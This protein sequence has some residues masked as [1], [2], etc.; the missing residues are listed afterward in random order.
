MKVPSIFLPEKN[1]DKKVADLSSAKPYKIKDLED[2]VLWSGFDT[3]T[4][5]ID[6]SDDVLDSYSLLNWSLVEERIIVDYEGLYV[7][8]MGF[9][10]E[11]SLRSSLKGVIATVDCYNKDMLARCNALFK[12][13]YLVFIYFSVLDHEK[14][15]NKLAEDY[16]KRGFKEVT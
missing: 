10:D 4:G 16:K 5:F 7:H 15:R 14:E 12:G 8:I 9:S 13:K 6:M 3:F 1:L 11:D 2:L